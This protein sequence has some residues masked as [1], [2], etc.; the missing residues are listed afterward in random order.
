MVCLDEDIDPEH[1]QLADRHD[2]IYELKYSQLV[3]IL[4]GITDDNENN[5]NGTSSSLQKKDG[6]NEDV[7]LISQKLTEAVDN[8]ISLKNGKRSELGKEELADWYRQ[9]ALLQGT[10]LYFLNIEM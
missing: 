5:D 6:R 2:V 1:S 10:Q 7:Q 4:N 3:N 8:T 9:Y